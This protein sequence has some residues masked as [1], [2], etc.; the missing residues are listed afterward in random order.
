MKNKFTWKRFEQSIK[1]ENFKLN[2]TSIAKGFKGNGKS[3]EFILLSEVR[4]KSDNGIVKGFIGE[5]KIHEP[6]DFSDI[7]GGCIRERK[8]SPPDISKGL[9]KLKEN[10]DI[11]NLAGFIKEKFILMVY[12]EQLFEFKDGFCHLMTVHKA[13][14][15]FREVLRKDELTET[16]T[17]KEYIELYNLLLIEPDIQRYEEFETPQHSLNLLDGTLDLRTM[18]L[19]RHNPQDGFFHCLE[20]YFND[21]CRADTG[22]V[23]ESFVKHISNGNKLIRQQLLELNALAI[24]NCEVKYF[25][26]LIGPSNTGKTQFGRFLQ[27]LVGRKNVES[28]AGVHDFANRFTTSAL[29]GKML[30]TCLDLPDTELP[31]VAVGT[32]KQFVG[33]DPIKVEK[34]YK[35]SMTIYKKPLLLFAGNHPMR[36]ANPSKE[37]ALLNRMVVIPFENPVNEGKQQHRLYELLI[38]E[39]PYIISQAIEAYQELIYRNFAVTRVEIPDEYK[40]QDTRQDFCAVKN[41]IDTCCEINIDSETTTAQM[42]KAYKKFASISSLPIISIVSFGR[43]LSEYIAY[44][45]DNIIPLK[46][47]G[48]EKQ[49]GYKGIRLKLE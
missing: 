13:A 6:I 24:V 14:T 2:K 17:R 19:R 21:I 35:D 4:Q 1:K 41:F 49:R 16:L 42:Y 12:N 23:F 38:N 37:Q 10:R 11:V 45:G 22:E 32:I 46:R 20:F 34:K 28:V 33:D 9:G 27:E 25:Y 44:L 39:A 36:I 43:L 31:S 15:R 26:V 7:K 40:T 47:V 29:A 5:D 3:K 18:N 8:V 48:I 30:G